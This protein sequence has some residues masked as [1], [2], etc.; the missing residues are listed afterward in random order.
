MSAAADTATTSRDMTSSTVRGTSTGAC[1]RRRTVVRGSGVVSRPIR[2][3]SVTMPT[4]RPASSTT[5]APLMS[6][7]TSVA[8]ACLM[9]VSRRRVMTGLVMISAARIGSSRSSV[10]PQ[11]AGHPAQR[12][13][14]YVPTGRDVRRVTYLVTYRVARL[15]HA[16]EADVASAIRR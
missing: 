15:R 8:A 13:G 4:S 2:S 11:D 16:V 5:G 9:W 12:P 7:P 10:R 3:A 1:A 14:P 6:R